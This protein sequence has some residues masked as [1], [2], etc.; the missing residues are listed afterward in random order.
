MGCEFVTFVTRHWKNSSN[1]FWNLAQFLKAF[2]LTFGPLSN[3]AVRSVP[4]NG[5]SLQ[6]SNTG[7]VSWLHC[8]SSTRT[9]FYYYLVFVFNPFTPWILNLHLRFSP[10]V[11]LIHTC[12]LSYTQESGKKKKKTPHVC[13]RGFR[14]ALKA[15]LSGC[16]GEKR[17]CVCL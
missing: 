7:F 11:R 4:G 15:T 13:V 2:P 8:C 10:W 17:T 12:L 16:S 9:C 6:T 3:Q 5:I 14:H 1:K